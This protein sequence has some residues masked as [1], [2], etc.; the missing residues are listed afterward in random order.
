MRHAYIL[1][2]RPLM[3]I[4]LTTLLLLFSLGLG[5]VHAYPSAADTG[6]NDTD[7]P[8]WDATKT[9]TSVPTA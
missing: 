1:T 8:N 3:Y 2:D 5:N 9:T 6:I 7:C 4:V